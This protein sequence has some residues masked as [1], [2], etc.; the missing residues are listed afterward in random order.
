LVGW[1]VRGTGDSNDSILVDTTPIEKKKLHQLKKQGVVN[2]VSGRY[3]SK[4][5]VT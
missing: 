3:F 1:I 2:K 4:N 5:F